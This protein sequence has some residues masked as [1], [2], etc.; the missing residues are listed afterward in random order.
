MDEKMDIPAAER[1]SPQQETIPNLKALREERGL[2]L[3]D[4]F[5]T[6]RV[7]LNYLA[8]VESGEFTLLPP[9]VYARDF[10]RKYAQTV[11]IDEKPI[12]SSYEKH[13]ESLKPK[14]KE[15]EIQ[16]PW[17]ET[18]RNNR[19]LFVS[20]AAVI[21]AGTL[22]SA[23][24]LYDQA[25]KPTSPPPV[26]DSPSPAPVIAEPSP[27]TE[28]ATSSDQATTRGS[29]TAPPAEATRQ[30][31]QPQP[32]A[33][34]GKTHH[35]MIETHELTWIRITEDRNPSYQVLLRPGEKIERTASDFFQL[36]IGNAGGVNLT[37]QGK[38]LGSLGKSGQ[39][40][41][42]RLPEKESDQKTP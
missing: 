39:I 35:L 3:S 38:P 23:L 40:V 24:F 19:F 42:I 33:A 21:I 18:G 10:I 2:S 25:G 16:K 15:M 36:D 9:P 29:V 1:T 12:L 7:G 32:A 17:P 11:G 22:V 5:E 34:A 30:S 14:I 31:P 13:L 37:F 6:T 8:A 41:H 20:L 26:A 28:V 27:A 4:I